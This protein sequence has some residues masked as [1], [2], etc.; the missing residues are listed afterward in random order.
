MNDE[1]TPTPKAS[2]S[3]SQNNITHRYSEIVAPIYSRNK[4]KLKVKS[5]QYIHVERQKFLTWDKRKKYGGV[6]V[7]SVITGLPLLN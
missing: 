2:C 6:K 1:E 3:W 7:F 4:S 5:I